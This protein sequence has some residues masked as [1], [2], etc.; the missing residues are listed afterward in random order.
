MR[1]IALGDL[2]EPIADQLK[3]END[4]LVDYFDISSVDN[5]RKK[6][7]GFTTYSFGEAPS[8]ARKA[9]KRNGILVS[10]VRPNLNA[11]ALFD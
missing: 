11:V 10:T 1:K 5:V 2:C 8:R 9:V 7:T 4:T 6:I 3:L